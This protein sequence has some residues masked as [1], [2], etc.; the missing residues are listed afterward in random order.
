MRINTLD[1]F[2]SCLAPLSLSQPCRDCLAVSGEAGPTMCPTVFP[3]ARFETNY[4][5]M[6]LS[7]K[8]LENRASSGFNNQSQFRGYLEAS[9]CGYD[10]IVD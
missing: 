8:K 1:Y 5:L 7:K 9:V 6:L 2:T 3:A 10:I 4:G